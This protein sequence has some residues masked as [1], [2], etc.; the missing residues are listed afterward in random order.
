MNI[1][2]SYFVLSSTLE[3][4]SC[5]ITI[6]TLISPLNTVVAHS[7]H[8]LVLY[9]THLISLNFKKKERKIANI[10]LSISLNIYFG[11]SK[12]PSH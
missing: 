7:L 12:E 6:E 1:F 11:C 4:P 9:H 8:E 5:T 10:F 2:L 3:S